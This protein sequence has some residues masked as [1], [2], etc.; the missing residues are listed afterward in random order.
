MIGLSD[1]FFIVGPLM[2]F[3][4]STI[5][6]PGPLLMT[7]KFCEDER[8]FFMETYKKSEFSTLGIEEAFV[9]DSHS[10]SQYGVLRG[11]HFQKKS[12][13]GKLVRVIHGEIFDVVV[14]IRKESP[15]FGKWTSLILSQ[16][17]RHI[18]YIP[19]GF[20][21]GFC[22]LSENAEILYKMTAE[23]APQDEKTLLW[24]DP[25]IGIRWP[26]TNP[27]VSEKDTAGLRI[28]AL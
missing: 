2:P 12:P 17:N 6:I 18:L 16:K 26:L 8:G 1:F 22:V 23:Y 20:A 25:K 27:I 15:H 7:P 19:A 3:E 14:D 5:D 9:Q 11:L 10:K 21:H 28:E 13:Q 4:S 24:N